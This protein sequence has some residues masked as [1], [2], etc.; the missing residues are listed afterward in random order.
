VGNL[1]NKEYH[2][3]NFT[4]FK[5]ILC[6][7]LSTIYSIVLGLGIPW[8]CRWLKLKSCVPGL[9]NKP[10]P[11]SMFMINYF[12]IY[13]STLVPFYLTS[14]I[15]NST[16][17]D[18]ILKDLFIVFWMVNLADLINWTTH[19]AQHR[20]KY[21][22]RQFHYLHH[23]TINPNSFSD[24][25]RADIVDWIIATASGAISVVVFNQNLLRI[26]IYGLII[27]GQAA[28]NHSGHYLPKIPGIINSVEHWGHHLFQNVNYAENF[29]LI[30]R[31][32]GTYMSREDVLKRKNVI[33][34]KRFEE[35]D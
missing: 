11:K 29:T 18:G 8:L 13:L 24:S 21:L 33:M 14:W 19:Y 34:M 2:M 27:A 20:I 10:I 5:A 15:D 1:Y 30:D 4:F 9:V 28:G 32:M 22:Y 31:L 16:T 6:S 25:T 3:Y 12:V 7:V 26:G 35:I 17:L 23:L